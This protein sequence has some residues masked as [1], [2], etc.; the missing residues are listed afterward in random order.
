MLELQMLPAREGDALWLRWGRSAAQRQILIDL[1]REETGRGMRARLEALP[2]SK[3][4]FDLLVITHVDRDHIG[5][6]L[7]GF[8][9][10]DPIPG[11]E[12][13][14]VWFNGWA[15]LDGGTIPPQPDPNALESMGPA[16]GERLTRWLEKRRWNGAFGGGPVQW[17]PGATPTKIDFGD[18]SLTVLGP[19]PTRLEELKPVWKE[20]VHKAL[21]KGSLTEVS[22]GLEIMGTDVEP[23][24]ETTDDLDFL[25]ESENKKDHSEANGSSIVL[26]VEYGDQKLLLSGDAFADDIVKAL[27]AVHPGG[28]L[29]VDAVKLPHHGSSKNITDALV[30]A[31]DTPRWLFSTDG[32]SFKHP[33]AIAIARVLRSSSAP[34][35]LIFNVPSTYN[36]WWD[37]EAWRT[38]FGY[39]AI[40]GDEDDGFKLQLSPLPRP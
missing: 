33:D 32:T 19:T 12:F 36:G 1:G 34:R 11:L 21:E 14:D 27:G 37:K 25:A 18:L 13:G 8:A 26:L 4:K 38:E 35:A 17:V 6:V 9:E 3:R 7:T 16:Q 24:L 15:H 39:T 20:E 5:G 2:E 10:A 31:V 29:P 40:Y 23:V 22:P 30:E 28:P